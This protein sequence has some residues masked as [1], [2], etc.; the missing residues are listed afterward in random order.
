MKKKIY[1][2]IL[3]I[4]IMSY[5][6]SAQESVHF[7]DTNL[8]AD[9]QETL[10][11]NYPTPK[12]AI[13]VDDD[14]PNDPG[15]NNPKISD[16]DEDG[17]LKHPFDSI[18]KAIE[19]AENGHTVLIYPGIYSEGIT[20]SG[21]ALTV[22]GIATHSGIPVLE[23]PDGYAVAFENGEGPD[24]ILTNFVIRNSFMAI[25]I[26]DCSPAIRNLTIVD[27]QY[28]IGLYN[29]AAPDIS[30]CILWRN[31]H[32]NLFQINTRYCCIEEAGTGEG[33]INLDPL[34]A[35]PNHGDY[36]L[37]SEYGRYSPQHDAWVFDEITSPC[38]S[39]GDPSTGPLDE[40]IPNSGRINMGAY[41]GTSYA[42]MGEPRP[43][44]PVY[45][46]DANLK[47]VVEETLGI[48]DP[49]PS[50]MLSLTVLYANDREI[51]DLTGLQYATNLRYLAFNRNQI[52][53]ISL[54][55]GLTK[56]DLLNLDF[57]PLDDISP[58]SE[59][60][61]LRT[62]GMQVSQISD[63]SSLSNLTKLQALALGGNQISDL[64]SL[65]NMTKL[66]SLCLPGNQI[67]DLSP[68]AGL[69][70]LEILYL[71]ENQI[72]DLS[73]L[74]DLTEL[75]LLHISRNQISNISA[76]AGP[77]N[78]KN[79][80]LEHNQISDISALAELTNLEVLYLGNNQIS[81][82][83]ILAN[84][85]NLTELLLETNQINDMSLSA[86]ANLTNLTSLSLSG[87]QI[88]DISVLAGLTNL[89]KLWLYDNQISDISA[90]AGM[91]NLMH[92][93]L[94]TNQISDISVLSGM[95]NMQHL[96]LSS[97]PISDIS[98][99]TGL[100]NLKTL[101][102]MYIPLNQYSY[103]NH[104]PQILENNPGIM[105]FFIPAPISN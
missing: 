38:I 62:L 92:L 70:S 16:P 7:D 53:D 30:N 80:R 60:V 36:H 67:N 25:F 88:S 102:I 9:L 91:T 47:A 3:L 74:A 93:D 41:G 51:S 5:L 46:A 85:T 79:L 22:Q 13:Y 100:M 19:A 73:A 28:D 31:T 44:E 84:L 64:S 83:S 24:S 23:N 27:N 1:F 2:I 35:D 66:R 101:F 48:T 54:L 34:L 61:N 12:N 11:V 42:S 99:L 105:I 104:L 10:D 21:K 90:L 69:M 45:F 65:S 4:S 87:S 39:A 40:P 58:L 26:E 82:I 6:A 97:N 59:L 98:V 96:M 75:T 52:S 86:L 49:R 63:I 81:D 89:E 103:D 77:M 18:Q 15:V 76:L 95:T 33:N 72:S 32:N 14:A 29:L 8:K 71:Q 43:E 68:L 37:L 56:L 50:D 78:L 20:F 55:S 17:S 57:N 94:Q